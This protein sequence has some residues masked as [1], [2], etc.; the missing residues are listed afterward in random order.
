MRR[1]NLKMFLSI[2]LLKFYADPVRALLPYPY[3]T[4]PATFDALTTE[5][6][7]ISSATPINL[8]MREKTL[9]TLTRFLILFVRSVPVENKA[10][11]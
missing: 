6:C 5:F 10:N 3:S 7:Q 4:P 8:I 11:R 2:N 1:D 9:R